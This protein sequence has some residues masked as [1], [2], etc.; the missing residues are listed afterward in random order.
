MCEALGSIPSTQN[1]GRRKEK[2]EREGGWE[3]GRPWCIC[4][5]H[6]I[7]NKA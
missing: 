3:G 4:V 1:E 7:N 5:I 6:K 2:E